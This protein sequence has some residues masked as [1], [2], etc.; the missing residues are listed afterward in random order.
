LNPSS[1]NSFTTS[2][3]YSENF[4]DLYY[5]HN[6]ITS[7]YLNTKSSSNIYPILSD[8]DNLGKLLFIKSSP[9]SAS[10]LCSISFGNLF[11][12]IQDI[13][14][15]EDYTEIFSLNKESGCNDVEHYY[16]NFMS[17]Y[18]LLIQDYKEF[19]ENSF[20]N[21]SFK[22]LFSSFC[23]IIHLDLEYYFNKYFIGNSEL[24]YSELFHIDKLS[25]QG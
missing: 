24:S 13:V 10:I 19:D 15:F 9:D 1:L 21:S 8:S 17:S 3:F 4:S 2:Q 20:Y 25:L 7:N 18:K 23:S 6:N 12:I 5:L 14:N 11:L 22:Y 16:T